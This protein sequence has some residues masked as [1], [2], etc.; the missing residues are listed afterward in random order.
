MS[1]EEQQEVLERIVDRDPSEVRSR[2]LTRAAVSR[3]NE[4]KDKLSE[5]GLLPKKPGKISLDGHPNQYGIVTH[6]LFDDKESM[7]LREGKVWVSR[8]KKEPKFPNTT[9]YGLMS[10]GIN[11]WNSSMYKKRFYDWDSVMHKL[12]INSEQLLDRLER[13]IP[14]SK[15]G[16]TNLA[17]TLGLDV[18]RKYAYAFYVIPVNARLEEIESLAR[19]KR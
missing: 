10:D 7:P 4:L 18:P 5:K 11:E 3:L 9:D 1:D 6:F 16:V 17:K 13:N 15:L 19:A 12:G 8:G 14:G 2:V